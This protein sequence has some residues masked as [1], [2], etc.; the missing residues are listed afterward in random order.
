VRVPRALEAGA[1]AVFWTAF[2]VG[3]SVLTL[4][5]PVY[6]SSLTQALGVPA[7]SGL[8]AVDV[9][10][11]SARVRSFVADPETEALPA[12]WKGRPAFGLSEVSH[13]RDVRAV[14]SGARTAT[15]ITAL[16]LA[17]YVAWCVAKKRF[18]R[19]RRGMAWG[20]AATAGVVVLAAAAALLDFGPFF[21]A[22]HGLFFADGTWTFPYDS[23]LIRL[24]PESFWVASG[25]AWAG[26]CIVAVCVL[27]LA[28]R[29]L[30]APATNECA[31]RIADNV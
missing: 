29:L 30:R 6:T 27:G 15:G 26:L 17:A 3:L 10:A 20:A 1:A 13:L 23:L 2:I 7:S 8:P 16:L 18:S 5:V 24:F 12:M 4:T 19:L 31:S 25:A 28:S 21:A 11:L 22:F 14:L 9:V